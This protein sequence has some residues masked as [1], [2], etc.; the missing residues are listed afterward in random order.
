MPK[1]SR[2]STDQGPSDKPIRSCSTCSLLDSLL[3]SQVTFCRLSRH[4]H[5]LGHV[6]STFLS[7]LLANVPFPL[8]HPFLFILPLKRFCRRVHIIIT[9]IIILVVSAHGQRT[10]NTTE[11]VFSFFVL[12]I[13]FQLSH[14]ESHR[15]PTERQPQSP[16]P[17][18]VLMITRLSTC[19]FFPVSS[20]CFNFELCP[21][22]VNIQ[23]TVIDFHINQ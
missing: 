21:H 2:S 23:E 10:T 14:R 4:S 16:S 13:N 15:Q 7:T 8:S 20:L 5:S 18:H 1:E 3:L 12:G 22:S 17:T 11:E 9:I 19:S 6:R